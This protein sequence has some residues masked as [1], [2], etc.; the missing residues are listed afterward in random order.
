MKCTFFLLPMRLPNRTNLSIQQNKIGSLAT[1]VRYRL[2]CLN[3]FRFIHCLRFDGQCK[4]LVKGASGKA[5]KGGGGCALLYFLLLRF[6]VVATGGFRFCTFSRRWKWHFRH[7]VRQHYLLCQSI[8]T[9]T[10]LR[11]VT[12]Y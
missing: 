7:S 4:K 12:R 9:S 11:I 3:S 6:V 10:A 1:A 5:P 8:M 2:S